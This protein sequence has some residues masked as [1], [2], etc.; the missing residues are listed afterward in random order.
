MQRIFH[1]DRELI[2]VLRQQLEGEIGGQ[3]VRREPRLGLRLE[4]AHDEPADFLLE[5]RV[6]VGVAQH[7]KVRP[8]AVDDVRHHV[9]VLGRVQR[10]IHP[11]QR[12]DLLGPLPGAVDD[13][14][15][16]DIAPRGA[17]AGHPAA[18]GEYPGHPG[19]LADPGAAVARAPG[20]RVREVRGVGRP[21]ARQPQRPGQVVAPHHRVQLDRPGRADQL[22]VQPVRGRGRRGPP[23]LPQPLGRAGHGD[24]AA[25]AEPGRE[26]G[27]G[28][29]PGVQLGGILHQLRQALRR[30]QLADQAGRVPGGP[31]G[32]L[33]LLEQQQVG[34]AEPG[35]VVGDAG[36]DHTAADDDHPGATGQRGLSHRARPRRAARGTRPRSAP[37]RRPRSAPSP[38]TRS[39][40][41]WG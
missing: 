12:A 36:A 3:L 33:A 13:D 27:L 6:A 40:S 41:L 31:A 23:Q 19:A 24:P 1:Q 20:Q 18:V 35:Q 21:V 26:P 17:H 16:L 28:L 38:T 25:P 9:E 2:P 5:V 29:E 34:P 39:R 8:D 11:A 14:L 15:G 30:A 32:Q 7:R 4:P 37:R 10:H 22:A